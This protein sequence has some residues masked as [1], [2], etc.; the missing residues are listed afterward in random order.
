MYGL[1][2]L[3]IEYIGSF[4]D[5]VASF[6]SWITGYWV[7]FIGSKVFTFTFNN[8]MHCMSEKDNWEIFIQ[9]KFFGNFCCNLYQTLFFVYG[10]LNNGLLQYFALLFSEIVAIVLTNEPFLDYLMDIFLCIIQ[11]EYSIIFQLP[12][13]V[14]LKIQLY[15]ESN[16][17]AYL[18]SK[19]S[20]L[21][22]LYF[23]YYHQKVYQWINIYHVTL[24]L[25]S[26]IIARIIIYVIIQYIF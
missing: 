12:M 26:L 16:V 20:I 22:H 19:I 1:Y 11:C 21:A 24:R 6:G 23:M 2:M 25:V 18:L 17:L 5:V 13:D 10:N 8:A 4:M 14:S 9:Y 3:A 7:F 15:H